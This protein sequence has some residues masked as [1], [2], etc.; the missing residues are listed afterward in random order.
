MKQR[1]YKVCKLN[2]RSDDLMSGRHLIGTTGFPN[3]T[4]ASLEI[5]MNNISEQDKLVLQDLKK[6]LSHTSSDRNN[7]RSSLFDKTVMAAPVAAISALIGVVERST[8]ETMMGLQDELKRA[9]ECMAMFYPHLTASQSR[10]SQTTIALE[11]GCAL[12]LKYSTR[13]FLEWPDY[14][15]CREHLL[16]RAERFKNASLT[17]RDVIAQKAAEFVGSHAT[18]L[19]HGWSRVVAGILKEAARDRAFHLFILEGRPD[20]SGVQAAKSYAAE[21]KN[22]DVTVVLDSAVMRILEKVD[23]VLVGAEG[24]VE[25]GGIVNKVGTATLAVC[26]KSLNK[27]FYVAAESYKFARLY[28]LRQ[29]DL[30][31]IEGSPLLFTDSEGKPIDLR[32]SQGAKEIV[33]TNGEEKEKT[34]EVENPTVDFT[35]AEY[36]S[37]LFTDLGV[38]TPSA[39]SDELIRLY[40]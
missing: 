39:V 24:V 27:P 11:S 7:E 2:G 10:S 37:L 6:F 30:P 13:T 18:I 12:F 5:T 21:T 4:T 15:S 28:P 19:T 31:D 14:E 22:I 20:G 38:L 32:V 33:G 16:M 34:I 3:M 26:A 8:S 23:V 17:A 29:S 9:S 36:I 35:P 25:N 40:Q 1:R